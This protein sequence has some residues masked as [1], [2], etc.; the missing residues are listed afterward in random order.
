VK[1][2]DWVGVAWVVFTAIFW[3]AAGWC[4]VSGQ[5]GATFAYVVAPLVLAPGAGIVM[6][7]LDEARHPRPGPG[8]DRARPELVWAGGRGKAPASGG[9]PRRG[10]SAAFSEPQVRRR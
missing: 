10:P 4:A 5:W 3:S 7:D 1:P 2:S 6:G 8:Q 9:I